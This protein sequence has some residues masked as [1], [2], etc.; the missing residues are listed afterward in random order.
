VV[1]EDDDLVGSAGQEPSRSGCNIRLHLRSPLEPVCSLKGE[2]CPPV[3][4]LGDS[5]HV[6][7]QRDAHPPTVTGRK[8]PI[9][10]GRVTRQHRSPSPE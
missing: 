10:S 7:A 8:S 3:V 4:E 2:N 9:K 1:V 6:G 5:L